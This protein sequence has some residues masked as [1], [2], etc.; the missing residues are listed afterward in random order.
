MSP[1]D[2]QVFACEALYDN[3]LAAMAVEAGE[4]LSLQT[5]VQLGAE[6][7]A[8][9]MLAS[10]E[11]RGLDLIK[12]HQT[13]WKRVCEFFGAAV[14]I[15]EPLPTDGELLCAY[16]RELKRLAEITKD[17]LEFYSPSSGERRDYRDRKLDSDEF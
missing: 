3:K 11:G 4:R 5:V 9:Y 17:R 1:S 16:R 14:S 12:Q 13:L 10:L 7:E 8:I 15:W 2:F 6:M